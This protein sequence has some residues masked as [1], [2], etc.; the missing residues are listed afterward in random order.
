GCH[1]G[2]CL[3]LADQHDRVA[4]GTVRELGQSQCQCGQVPDGDG[5]AGADGRGG[6][7]GHAER[8]GL[9]RV[10]VLGSIRSTLRAVFSAGPARSPAGSGGWMPVV[11][12]PYTGAWQNNAEL[13]LETAFANP[14]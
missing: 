9:T 4:R 11:H 7:R 5:V 13:R 3:T 10:S 2:L 1:H 8:E 14:V 12:E 6:G